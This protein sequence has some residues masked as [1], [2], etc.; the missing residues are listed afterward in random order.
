[1]AK[2]VCVLYEDPITVGAILGRTGEILECFLS[3]R[4]IRDGCVIVQGGG[5][6]GTDAVPQLRAMT[7]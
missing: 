7:R 6:A 1:M 5:L 3:G 4:L 2:I